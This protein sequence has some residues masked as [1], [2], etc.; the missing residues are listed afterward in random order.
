MLENVRIKQRY[1]KDKASVILGV[2]QRGGTRDKI[3]LYRKLL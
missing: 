2:R 1:L 3:F